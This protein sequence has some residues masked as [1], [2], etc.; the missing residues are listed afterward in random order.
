MGVIEGLDMTPLRARELVVAALIATIT[1]LGCDSSNEAMLEVESL[2]IGVLPGEGRDSLEHQFGPLVDYFER[3]LQLPCELVLQESYQ[4]LQS[5]FERG[6]VDLAWF[7]GYTF[8]NVH[9]SVDAHPLVSRVRD[10]H[11]T[12]Y[13]LV[14]ADSPIKDLADCE[15]KT[16]AFG[17]RLST[18][19]HLMPRHYLGTWGINPEEYFGD[20]RFTGAHDITVFAVRDGQVD[21][22]VANSVTVDH[23]FA[24]G[25][26]SPDEVRI[27]KVTPPYID[28]VWACQAKLPASFRNTLRE[29]FLKLSATD[30]EQ[31]KILSRLRADYFVPVS[32][33]RFDTLAEII[34]NSSLTADAR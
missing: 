14:N 31:A 30:E 24:S 11:F 34:D 5:A 29:A 13:F 3:E 1:I 15:D 27:L 4:D 21:V 9:R 16:F 23:L 28:Y 26:L 32:A 2:R 22:G 20:I 33:D 19:G 12:S 17:S 25:Q 18:S 6:K 8:V 7:G 10:Q